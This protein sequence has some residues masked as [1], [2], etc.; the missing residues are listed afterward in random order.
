MDLFDIAPSGAALPNAPLA[1][2]MRP[3]N[4]DEVAGQ[5]HLVGRG[6][7]LRR[8]IEQDQ[9]H[10]FILY[11]PPGSGKTSLAKIIAS[12]TRSCF[13]PLQA[14]TAGVG[15]IRKIAA[16][17]AERMKYYGHK[18]ILFVDE[19]HRFN[20]SQQDVLLPFV[21]DGTLLL[22]GSTTENPL[23]ELNNALLSRAK[24]YI[25][26]PLE[27]ADIIGIIQKALREPERGLGHFCIEIDSQ[28]LELITTNA[29]GDARMALNILEAV[30]NS[31]MRDNRLTINQDLLGQIVDRPLVKYD[32]TGDRHYDSIS[33]FI[34]SIRGSDPDA[35]LF[36]LAVML[37]GG[38]DPLYIARRL[39]V[40]AAEDVG[41]ADPSALVLAQATADAVRFLGMPEARIP[42][43]ESAIY[44]ATAPKSNSS[45]LAIDAAIAAVRTSKKITVPAHIA[46]TSHSRAG[47]LLGKGKGYKY[48]HDY[49]GFIDQKYLPEE[50]TGTTF[51]KPVE[52]GYEINIQ[53]YLK[54]L[55][56]GPG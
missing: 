22:I 50:L 7:V 31:F 3:R 11:G 4:L 1:Y 51:Y 23:Y 54:K 15:D 30:V 53:Q 12:I 27:E 18:T 14:V 17:A 55:R 13:V 56:G 25:L 43:S 21:E 10:S 29:K 42:L 37:E 33:A 28:S 38:E 52:Q 36:W 41:L 5:Q 8:L 6:A 2:R 45:K 39:V 47:E 48:P 9:L 24:L 34:K 40:H 35:T 20:K 46:D 44:L 49:G 19:I 32:K 26:N 16:D